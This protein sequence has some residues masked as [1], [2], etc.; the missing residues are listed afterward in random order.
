MQSI[1]AVELR[2]MP[3]IKEREGFLT[4]SE[5]ARSW[6]SEEIEASAL[7]LSRPDAV[8]DAANQIRV[9]S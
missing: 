7:P 4:T 2:A 5:Q 3:R 9:E 8:V 6:F 1:T